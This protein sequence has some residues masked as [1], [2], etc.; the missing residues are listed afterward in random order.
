MLAKIAEK[1][2]TS[3]QNRPKLVQSAKVCFDRKEVPMA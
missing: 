2:L 1:A 3:V